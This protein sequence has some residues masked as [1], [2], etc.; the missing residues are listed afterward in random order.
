MAG[1]YVLYTHTH[2]HAVEET[3]F[4]ISQSKTTILLRMEMKQY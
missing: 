2:T 1:L 3:R 4:C